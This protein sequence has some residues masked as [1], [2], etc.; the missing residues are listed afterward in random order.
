MRPDFDAYPQP[1][2][3]SRDSIEVAL[4][5]M[6]KAMTESESWAAYN[7]LLFAVGNNHR[8]TFYPVALAVVPELCGKLASGSPWTA[9]SAVNVLVELCSFDPEPGYVHFE[10]ANVATRIR[11]MVLQHLNSIELLAHDDKVAALHARD[12]L[13]VLTE[14]D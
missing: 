3:N 7:E 13:A 11:A 1:E 12:L 14:Q 6:D 2:W 5:S 4:S 9:H 8:G 10:G